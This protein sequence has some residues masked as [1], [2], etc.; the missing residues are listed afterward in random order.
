MEMTAYVLKSLPQKTVQVPTEEAVRADLL[1]RQVLKLNGLLAPENMNRA[2]VSEH[3]ALK[4]IGV[5]ARCLS[6]SQSAEGTDEHRKLQDIV[7]LRTC[8]HY[9]AQR[10]RVQDGKAQEECANLMGPLVYL[11]GELE[12]RD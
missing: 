6:L 10:E 9:L 2:V 8:A 4:N 1:V 12:K 3:P 7:Y 5:L 11:I